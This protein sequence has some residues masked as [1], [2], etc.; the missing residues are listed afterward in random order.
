MRKVQILFQREASGA[1]P[2]STAYQT[3]EVFFIEHFGV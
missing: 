2:L 1:D 3:D